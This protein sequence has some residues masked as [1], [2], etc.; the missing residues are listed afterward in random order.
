MLRRL[1]L[2]CSLL[3]C[4]IP[5]FAA[6]EDP[7]EQLTRAAATDAGAGWIFGA[8]V[9]V[10]QP[11]YLGDKRQ[12][13]PLPLV[14]FHYGRFFFAGFAAGYLLDNGEHYRLSLGVQPW[15]NR[16]NADDS[17][18]LAGIQSRKWT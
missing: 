3:L 17:P 7:Q 11:G 15:I 1:C 4:T 10:T 6:D 16:L 14:F 5:A 9:A 12:I 2:L 8:G 13:T 18:Q